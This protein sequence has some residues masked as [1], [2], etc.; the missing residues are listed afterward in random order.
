MGLVDAQIPSVLQGT[1]V[2]WKMLYS[3][4]M[5]ALY[6]SVTV[7]I[8]SCSTI[9][10]QTCSSLMS[11]DLMDMNFDMKG[12]Q[13]GVL[14]TPCLVQPGMHMMSMS[15]KGRPLWS[16]APPSSRSFRPTQRKNVDHARGD[17]TKTINALKP[18][19]CFPFQEYYV[20]MELYDICLCLFG[21]FVSLE[22]KHC[23]V[24]FNHAMY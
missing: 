9:H 21:S 14:F 13:K 7:A 18:G 20:L 6:K 10:N 2:P 15:P 11:S 19:N 1:Y 24:L 12:S 16:S 8:F 22:C 17:Q 5:Y 4:F 3:N 23:C